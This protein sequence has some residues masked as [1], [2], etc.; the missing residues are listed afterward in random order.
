MPKLG[1]LLR[2]IGF[3]RTQR[4]VGRSAKVSPQP[5]VPGRYRTVGPERKYTQFPSAVGASPSNL[6]VF[7]LLQLPKALSPMF[8]T[9]AGIVRLVKPVH[10]R[11]AHWPIEVSP[12]PKIK[13]VRPEQASNV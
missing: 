2:T 1:P 12:L 8:V 5:A 7:K 3:G 10:A 11:N 6:T 13:L 4:A 9:E